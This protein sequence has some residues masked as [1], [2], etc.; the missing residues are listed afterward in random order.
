M[1]KL[2]KLFLRTI[3]WNTNIFKKDKNPEKKSENS[4]TVKYVF[5]DSG[6]R[7]ALLESNNST[8]E[9]RETFWD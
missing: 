3:V 5:T 9:T 8:Y 6:T 1:F 7:K 2:I 4:T